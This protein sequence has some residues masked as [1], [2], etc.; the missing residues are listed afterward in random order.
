MYGLRTARPIALGLAP[1][2][3]PDCVVFDALGAAA[4]ATVFAGLGYAFGN[5]IARVIGVATHYEALAVLGILL[6]G[7]SVFTVHRWRSGRART[8][9]SERP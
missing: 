1:V 5:A 6:L 8:M 9:Q 3:W 4:W 7:V 2:P